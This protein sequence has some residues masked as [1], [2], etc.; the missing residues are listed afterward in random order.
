MAVDRTNGGPLGAKGKLKPRFQSRCPVEDPF[1]AAFTEQP[2]RKASSI[3]PAN[4]SGG[5]RW[6]AVWSAL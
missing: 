6:E 5:R 4:T 1:S 3:V 2:G